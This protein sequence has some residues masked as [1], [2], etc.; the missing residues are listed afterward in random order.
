M[1]GIDL[2]DL[3]FQPFLMQQGDI[4]LLTT[5]GLY[6]ALS[7]EQISSI[8]NKTQNLSCVADALMCA[9]KECTT[10]LDNTTFAI[11]KYLNEE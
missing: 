11:I 7:L 6:H 4:L 3:N 8:L 9:V 10:S 2:V 5:D 1:G